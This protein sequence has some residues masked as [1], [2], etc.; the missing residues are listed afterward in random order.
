MKRRLRPLKGLIRHAAMPLM[1]AAAA[2][3]PSTLLARA[4]WMIVDL[5]EKTVSYS[6]IDLET[7][8]ATFNTDE[9]KKDKMVFRLVG[10]G[11]YSMPNSVRRRSR[12]GS[13]P[14]RVNTAASSASTAPLPSRRRP[15][16]AA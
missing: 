11:S 14:S 7:A 5:V 1:I 16:P 13:T 10:K 9:Y 2:L 12:A 4:T 6:D 8:K 3:A 15:S